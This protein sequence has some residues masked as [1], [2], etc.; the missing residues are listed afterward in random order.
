VATIQQGDGRQPELGRE[1]QPSRHA[2][3]ARAA[4]GA[5]VRRPVVAAGL[6][7]LLWFVW[8]LLPAPGGRDVTVSE[9]VGQR[10]DGADGAAGD[11]Q[12]GLTAA[13]P[14]APSTG[15]ATGPSAGAVVPSAAAE[16][17][18]APSVPS[19]PAPEA[20]P[21]EVPQQGEGTFAVAPGRTDV[22]GTG[23]LVTYSVEVEDGVPVPVPDVAA[24][25]DSA[26]ADPRSWTAE[27][28]WSLQRTDDEPQVRILVASPDTSD[29]LC[30]P[31]RTNGE[32]SC[33]NGGDVVLNALRWTEGAD[34]WGEDVAGY[35]QY[36][37]NHELGHFLGNGHEGCPQDGDP[38]PVMLQQ[39]LGLQGCVPNGWPYP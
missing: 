18:S 7:L 34:S 26:L 35:Q 16:A 22:V 27:G 11:Q 29:E 36:V 38:A 39:T 10:L 31:L 19:A 3:P 15:P 6:V 23:T 12:A 8:L 30:A 14:T 28:E 33:R 37:V 24:V 17:P 21:V 5:D 25:V 2:P 4:G 9:L 1:P 20:V 32:L 13:L